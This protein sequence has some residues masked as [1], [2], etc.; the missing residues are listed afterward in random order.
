MLTALLDLVLPGACVGCGRPGE[1]PLC[2]SCGR[3]DPA[4][5]PGLGVPAAAGG[6]YDAA[7]RQALLKYKER[8]RRDLAGLLGSYLAAALL[9]LDLPPGAVLV[10][11]PSSVAA[12]RERGGDHLRPV[13]RAAGRRCGVAVLPA[14]RL[15][16]AVQDSAGLTLAER[17]ANIDDALRARAPRY[18]R[19]SAVLVDDIVT[20]GATAREGVRALRAAGWTVCGAAMVAAT[21]PATPST[22]PAAPGTRRPGERTVLP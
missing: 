16:R 5:V 2:A 3:P 15:G 1:Q 20:T 4:V 6:S 18:P 21:P 7:L 11:V 14:L 19:R 8:G 12:R 9:R 13:A 22:T 17:A 10:P